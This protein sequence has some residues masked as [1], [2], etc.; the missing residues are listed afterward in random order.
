MDLKNIKGKV[1]NMPRPNHPEELYRGVMEHK[2]VTIPQK[3]DG[4]KKYPQ[5]SCRLCWKLGKRRDTRFMCYSCELPFCKN[6]CFEIHIN[7]I[8]KTSQLNTD[9]FAP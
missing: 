5:K 7:D 3:E 4:K 2:L 9:Y 6:P 1:P 8:I